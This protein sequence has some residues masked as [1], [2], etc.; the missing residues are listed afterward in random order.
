MNL[1]AQEK[2]FIHLHDGMLEMHKADSKKPAPH[3]THPPP[4]ICSIPPTQSFYSHH[5]R[6]VF[7]RQIP[8]SFNEFKTVT[9]HIKKCQTEDP[10]AGQITQ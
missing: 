4:V 6:S 7:S 5:K 8:E 9:C 10:A 1:L 3:L 2:R